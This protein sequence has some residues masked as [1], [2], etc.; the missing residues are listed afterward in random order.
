MS[1]SRYVLDTNAIV[2]LLQGNAQMIPL[3]QKAGWIGVSIISQIEFLVFPGLTESD[4]HLFQ[5]LTTSFEAA[6]C[7]DC[8]ND[9]SSFSKFSDG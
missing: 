9:D 7:S 8:C 2:A 1:G 6:R 3:I 4:R 5:A